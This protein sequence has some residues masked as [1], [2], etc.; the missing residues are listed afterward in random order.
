MNVKH[1]TLRDYFAG[2]ALS[3]LCSGFAGGNG[4]VDW[5]KQAGANAAYQ[6]ADAML[7]EREKGGGNE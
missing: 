5:F 3:G 4:G 6:I 7:A 1:M 2:Q